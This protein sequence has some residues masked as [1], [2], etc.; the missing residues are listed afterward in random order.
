MCYADTRTNKAR[1]VPF[2]SSVLIF[3]ILL[4]REIKGEKIATINLVTKKELTST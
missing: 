3:V 2:L 1:N 4:Q